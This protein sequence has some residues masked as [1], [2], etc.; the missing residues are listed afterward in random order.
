MPAM[1]SKPAAFDGIPLC[2]VRAGPDQRFG[3]YRKCARVVGEVLGK[4]HPHGGHGCVRRPWC[5][6]PQDF[7]MRMP[8]I[9]VHATSARRQHPP[10]AMP[11][12]ESRA[13]GTHH[14][15]P[16]RKTSKLEPSIHRTTST[17]SQQEPTV[18]AGAAAP[19]AAEC[20]VRIAVADGHQ[21]SPHNLDELITGLLAPD[22]RPGDRRP[23]P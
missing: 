4:Y 5:A 14:R 6:W 1:A 9:A 15:Q 22:R 3:P 20:F 13:A 12:H 8:L 23:A 18:D 17:S 7:S 19:P 2:D 21:H 11:V 10:A 16:A